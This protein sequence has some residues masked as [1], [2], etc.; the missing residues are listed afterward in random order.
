MWENLEVKTRISRKIDD[1]MFVEGQDYILLKTEKNTVGQPAK[2]Y[3]ISLEM[4][5]SLNSR[6]S[7]YLELVTTRKGKYGGT[8]VC[9]EIFVDIAMWLNPTFKAKVMI[10]VSDNLLGARNG[11]GLQCGLYISILDIYLQSDYYSDTKSDNDF[12]VSLRFLS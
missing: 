9:P 1:S 8:W 4:E 6:N 10:W 7:C 12:V 11:S 2:E 5:L 3:I